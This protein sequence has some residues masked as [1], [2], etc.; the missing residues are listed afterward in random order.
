MRV[1]NIFA[2]VLLILVVFVSAMLC[3]AQSSSYEVYRN[4]TCGF[5]LRYPAGGQLTRIAP[6]TVRI[7]LPFAP[8]TTLREKYLQIKVDSGKE[9]RFDNGIQIDGMKLRFDRGSEGAVGS[10]YDFIRCT[11]VFPDEC[12]ATLTFV[13]H[14]VNPGM[15]DSPP[16]AFDRV[17]EVLPFWSILASLR[18]VSEASSPGQ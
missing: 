14:S 5:E 4:L 12:R 18:P 16:P 15:F 8:G 2:A 17:K 10:I 3:F 9:Y 11:V 6:D 1:R 13:L 7:D